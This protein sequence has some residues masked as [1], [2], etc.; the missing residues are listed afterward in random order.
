[1]RSFFL[2]A[3]ITIAAVASS[4]MASVDQN[5]GWS[6]D[7]SGGQSSSIGSVTFVTE[8]GAPVE[9]PMAAAQG[10]P[11]LNPGADVTHK[12]PGHHSEITDTNG[13][14]GV[15]PT[16]PLP[17]PVLLAALGLAAVVIGRGQLSR[18]IGR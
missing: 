17:A 4:S 14:A 5:N 9:V 7:I 16:V 6:L 12:D 18:F 3:V 10:N 8:S 13:G 1:M 2:G 11:G 15:L